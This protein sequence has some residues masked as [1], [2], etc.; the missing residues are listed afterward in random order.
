MLDAIIKNGTIIDGSGEKRYVS[1]I[2]IKDGKIVEIGNN[3]DIKSKKIIDATNLIVA[4]GF[5]ESHG[6]TDI[7]N[8]DYP[9]NKMDQGIT[10]EITG[11]CGF[12]NHPYTVEGK[13][14]V[15]K[16][17]SY[18]G[19]PFSHEES[20]R[21][22]KE[23]YLRR[24]QVG[25][26]YNFAALVGMGTLRAGV[27][28]LENREA[29][30][31]EINKMAELLEKELE[32]G[33]I[34]LSLG[35]I[36]LPGCFSTPKEVEALA[37]VLAKH[38]K[39]MTVHMRDEADKFLESIDEM[40]KIADKFKIKVMVSHI[41]AVLPRN[42]GKV[43][44]AL[45]KMKAARSKGVDIWADSYFSPYI[46]TTIMSL[47]PRWAISG[48]I[49]GVR[50]RLNTPEDRVKIT[51]FI[52]ENFIKVLHTGVYPFGMTSE[53]FEKFNS[54]PIHEISQKLNLD[55]IE[56]VYEILENEDGTL[57]LSAGASEEDIKETV[58]ESFVLVGS[59][60]MP[61]ED[62]SAEYSNPRD[63]G[64]FPGFIRKFVRDEKLLSLEEAIMRMTKLTAEFYSLPNRGEL[65]EGYCADIIIFDE[66][67]I[68]EGN[69]I[70]K[71][72]K[73]NKGIRYLMIN[74]EVQMKDHEHF[75]KNVGSVILN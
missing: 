47:L 58:K 8:I 25:L 39:V 32:M 41:K 67:K 43:K 66:E 36:Y 10:T 44:K 29:T 13:E 62:D 73:F 34:G 40:I 70:K 20:S 49:E 72:V 21:N 59:D 17:L 6:H 64:T 3:I 65:K 7:G 18:L 45:D 50:K 15:I 27:I 4:P 53:K 33:A 1:D 38:N 31:E 74:G 69:S 24:D 42:W 52:N 61:H 56:V 63:F 5:I 71:P 75:K 68:S 51:K 60:A 16:T 57:V 14:N 35:L 55:P 2:G 26:K 11:H 12:S 54:T 37:A 28:G 22:F 48:S 46:T 23:Y 30:D 19:E 9:I